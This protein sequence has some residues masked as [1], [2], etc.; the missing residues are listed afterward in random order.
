VASPSD[1]G[2]HAAAT[3]GGVTAEP[4][5]EGSALRISQPDQRA[6]DDQVIELPDPQADESGVLE[7]IMKHAAGRLVECPLRPP[8]C[9]GARL[10][11]N[12]DRRLVLM[13]AARS[14]LAD[15]RSIAQAYHW[16]SQNRRLIGMAMPQLSVDAERAPHL[17]LY[18]DQRDTSAE[19]LRPLLESQHVS[20]QSYRRL[21]WGSR[22]GLLLDAA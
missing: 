17:S 15:L 22:V 18:I 6:P 3:I 12:R 2:E 21:R 20:V 14:G 1:A 19:I 11:V 4:V 10:A 13:A 16:L 5:G 7:S 8:M 9:Q